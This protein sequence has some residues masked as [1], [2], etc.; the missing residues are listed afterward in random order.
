MPRV[1]GRA[2]ELTRVDAALDDVAAGRGAVLLIAGPAGI[3]K[4]RLVDCLVTRA[5][6]R[7][8]AATRGNCVPD[9][10][11]PALWPWWQALAD[12]PELAARLDLDINGGPELSVAA[13]LRAFD[14]LLRELSGPARVIVLEDLHW[15]DESTLTLLRLAVGRP[16]LLVAA[17]YRDDEQGPALRA[18]VDHLRR[19]A[20][21]VLL[22]L[23]PWGDAEVAEF[24]AGQ[25]DPSWAGLLR[26]VSGGNPLFAGELLTALTSAGLDR[27][28]ATARWPLGVPEQLRG[29]VAA[30]L[31][32][33][34]PA[35]A[36]VARAC[37]VV[38]VDSSAEEIAV[39]V[40]EPPDSVRAAVDDARGL[41]RQDGR[42]AFGHILVRDAVYDCV[43]ISDRLRW[44]R[45]LADAVESGVVPG[46]S[47]THRLRSITDAES[48]SAAIRACRDAAGK[49]LS[50]LA[51]DRAAELYDA[52]A[53]VLAPDD[54]AR[55]DLLLDAAE[56][57]YQAGH[58]D[59]AVGRCEE[60]AALDPP[61]DRLV[62]AALTVRGING[63]VSSRLVLLCDRALPGADD[64]GRARVLAQRALALADAVH[65]DQAEAPSREALELAERTGDPLALADA[66][67]ARQQVL[68][69]P[70]HVAERLELARRMLALG[71]DAPP[72]GELWARLWRIDAA[73]QLGS[74][75][76]LDD[77]L[78]LL[79][80]YADRLG[81]PNAHWHHRRMSAV[82]SLLLGAFDLAEAQA[83]QAVAV[84]GELPGAA[85]AGLDIAFR[86]ELRL[87]QGR[88]EEMFG[89][90]A[91]LV[92]RAPMMVVYGQV[93]KFLQDAGD[94]DGALALFERLR[95]RLPTLPRE[96]R[97]LPTVTSA[98][99]LAA[100]FGDLDTAA[101]CYDELLPMAQY[102]L[103][104]GSGT[105]VCL[106]SMSRPLGRV[107]A[108]LGRRDDAIRHFENAIAMDGR[109]GALPY[110]ARGEVGLA[111]VLA[112]G[113][114]AD[115]ARAGKLAR[116]AA[117][118]ARRLGMPPTV[119]RADAVLTEV[120]RAQHDAVPLTARERE[121]LAL[122]AVG[123][124]NR[125]IADKLVL[126]ERTVETHV[127]NV[128]GKL[129]VANRAQAATWA[130]ENGYGTT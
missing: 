123:A 40:G 106:G 116:Q 81:L 18:A 105:V 2:T 41:L 51:Y 52:A 111:E 14:S 67:R 9:E 82:R 101:R 59:A 121:V 94:S 65:Q 95:P 31:D 77:E 70:W 103:A 74:M 38:G 92:A 69:G 7:A 24:V 49:A 122:L 58:I 109:I 10:G 6:E 75:A 72:D 54:P 128:L 28:P 68:S 96:G 23:G 79:K 93:G 98:A 83:D 39:L 22:T 29:I 53:T 78:A 130:V 119:A 62:R 34:P 3:G 89:P 76:A 71:S 33:L 42:I 4:T 85:A 124:P 114:Q 118:T 104:A 84:A 17:T 5:A 110:R 60:V 107:A 88:A 48:R 25:A 113:G 35:A 56:M 87:M 12:R 127:S 129:G 27:S 64:A 102:F 100:D 66:L 47:V 37:A 112:G 32:A 115:L 26:R 43:S 13:R 50:R 63:A 44:H 125:T 16:G 30:R 11:A 61:P 57:W 20:S 46:E 97:W 117:V 108:A 15:A 21:T 86:T 45:K 8:I 19:D 55:V 80:L 91:E 99:E 73:L 90:V 120:R 1:I 126:S 36:R